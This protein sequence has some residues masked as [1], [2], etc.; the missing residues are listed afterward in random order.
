MLKELYEDEK[1]KKTD[2]SKLSELQNALKSTTK[3]DT[4]KLHQEHLQSLFLSFNTTPEIGL[5]REIAIKRLASDGPNLLKEKKELP[6]VLRLLK[7]MVG[8]F[9]ILL[10]VGAIL[11]FIAYGFTPSDKSNVLL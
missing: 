2:K 1:A 10:W 7:E 8:P 3:I 5:S 9:A 6:G 11:S 4:L